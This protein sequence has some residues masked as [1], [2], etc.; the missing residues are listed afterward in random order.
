MMVEF[1]EPVCPRCDGDLETLGVDTGS[2]VG[3]FCDGCMRIYPD[4]TSSIRVG[5]PLTDVVE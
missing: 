3:W 4:K 5:H 2:R 1:V